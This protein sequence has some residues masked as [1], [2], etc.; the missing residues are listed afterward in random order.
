M[1]LI[2]DDSSPVKKYIR[3]QAIDFI[4][5]DIPLYELQRTLNPEV[6]MKIVRE[7]LKNGIILFPA[8]FILVH[9]GG[10]YKLVDGQHR[11]AA[12]KRLNTEVDLTGLT[13]GI[14]S[15]FCGEDIRLAE[16]IYRQLNDQYET[17][18]AYDKST[19]EIFRETHTISKS[20]IEKLK[21]LFPQHIKEPGCRFPNFDPNNFMLKLNQTDLPKRMDANTIIEII[22]KENDEFGLELLKTKPSIYAQCKKKDGFFLGYGKGKANCGWIVDIAKKY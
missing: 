12:L 11:L 14:E 8:P 18:G 9:V 17:N 3:V 15:H 21:V 13:V 10:V 22:I 4:K 16:R 7:Q 19:G 6:V 5:R 2:L 20:V 1:D